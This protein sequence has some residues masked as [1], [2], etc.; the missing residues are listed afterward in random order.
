M[1]NVT[2]SIT[3]RAHLAVKIRFVKKKIP[4]KIIYVK[5]IFQ[6]AKLLILSVRT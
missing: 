4:F 3:R 1:T 6:Y 5:I 2:I